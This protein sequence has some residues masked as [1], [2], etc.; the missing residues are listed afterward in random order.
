MSDRVVVAESPILT[1]EACGCGVMHLHFGPISMRFTEES[2][3]TV[4]RT[5]SQALLQ[6]AVGKGV[7]PLFSS[8]A[9]RG[10]A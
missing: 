9:V 2:L 1:I 5:I 8:E 3:E 7:T 10:E 6:R 4:Q